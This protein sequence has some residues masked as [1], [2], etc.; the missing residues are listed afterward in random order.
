MTSSA[1]PSCRRFLRHGWERPFP[2]GVEACSQGYRSMVTEPHRMG[3]ERHCRILN[4]CILAVRSL[5]RSLGPE[6]QIKTMRGLLGKFYD[7]YGSYRLGRILREQAR[8]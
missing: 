3:K 8:G 7:H 5:R 2:R 4:H 6:G 1:K